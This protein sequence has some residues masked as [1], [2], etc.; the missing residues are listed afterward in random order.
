[1]AMQ[2]YPDLRIVEMGIHYMPTFYRYGFS[3]SDGGIIKGSVT[4]WSWLW[5]MMAFNLSPHVGVQSEIDYYKATQ[6]YKD[7]M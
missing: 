1:M 6:R 7:Q 4:H 3:T 5:C 2:A